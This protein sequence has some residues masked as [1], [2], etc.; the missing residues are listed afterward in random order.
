MPL[1]NNIYIFPDYMLD[2]NN[3]PV[4][5]SYG[6]RTNAW[7]AAKIAKLGLDETLDFL[8]QTENEI[9]LAIGG[10]EERK[11]KAIE[12]FERVGDASN[13]VGIGARQSG[14]IGVDNS[15]I[16]GIVGEN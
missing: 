1:I 3:E 10:V 2:E 11:N 8:E 7:L 12:V 14:K 5:F 6:G 15:V 13:Q 9:L 4:L 16:V